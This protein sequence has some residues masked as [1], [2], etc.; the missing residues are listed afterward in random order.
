ME[1]QLF[2]TLS[3]GAYKS[4][5]IGRSLRVIKTIRLWVAQKCPSPQNYESG[6]DKLECYQTLIFRYSF[7]QTKNFAHL[8]IELSHI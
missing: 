7:E 5:Y 3:V 8:S 1:K 4:N 2:T 6:G